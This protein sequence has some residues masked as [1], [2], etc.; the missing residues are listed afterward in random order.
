MVSLSSTKPNGT[1]KLWTIPAIP[2]PPGVISNFDDPHSLG[3]SPVVVHTAF[4]GLNLRAV[5][6]RLYTKKVV[7]GRRYDWSDGMYDGRIM[8][9]VGLLIRYSDLFSCAGVSFL[10]LTNR[11]LLIQHLSWDP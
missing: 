2:P 9:F 11:L 3:T 6:V 10:L 5:A 8:R 1:L 7:Q 4:L